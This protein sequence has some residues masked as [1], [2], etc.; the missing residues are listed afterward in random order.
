MYHQPIKQSIPVQQPVN[1]PWLIS[2]SDFF[3]GIIDWIGKGLAWTLGKIIL[4]TI[5]G[6]IILFVAYWVGKKFIWVP[7]K[8]IFKYLYSL[9]PQPVKDILN[10]IGKW[11]SNYIG[12]KIST[13][14]IGWALIL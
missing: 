10:P 7:L 13:R 3:K 12:K 8:R 6:A 9:L 2:I 4:G 1:H 5:S 14:I 11:V